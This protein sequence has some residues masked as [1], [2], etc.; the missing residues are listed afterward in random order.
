MIQTKT[1][2]T[3]TKQEHVAWKQK[4]KRKVVVV[5]VVVVTTIT[6]LHQQV[7]EFLNVVFHK[8]ADQQEDNI[9]E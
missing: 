8:L 9:V 2:Q 1:I 4:L 6:P 5:V 7:V 3:K